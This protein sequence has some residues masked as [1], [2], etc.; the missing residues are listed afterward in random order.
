MVRI[1][2]LLLAATLVVPAGAAAQQTATASSP[3]TPNATD[4]PG[5]PAVDITEW[6][7]S[8]GSFS[9]TFQSDVPRRLTFS[10]IDNSS[11]RG[12]TGTI[13][14][15]NIP[16]GETT[17]TTP[18]PSG[19]VWIS[20]DVSTSNGRFYQLKATEDASSS[21]PSN[22]GTDDLAAVGI[23]VALVFTLAVAWQVLRARLGLGSGGERLA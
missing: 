12:S 16:S 11:K 17:L 6:R 22:W 2:L 5:D 18:A 19:T 3:T 21:F 7:Y 1:L 20:T 9:I 23:A 15:R 10:T 4:F 13:S 14:S 8:D